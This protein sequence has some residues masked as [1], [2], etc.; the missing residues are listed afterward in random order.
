MTHT[1]TSITAIP[2]L[3]GRFDLYG[4]V[5]KGLRKAGCELLVRLGS[6]DFDQS[7]DT[8]EVLALLRTYLTLAAS[9]V[10]HED[11]HIH[12]ALA[13]RGASTDTVDHQHDDHREAFGQLEALARAV[14]TAWPMHRRATGRKL[15]LAF[16]A[17][18]AEDLA[19]MHEEETVTARA[20]WN[21][22]TDD[23]LSA[24]EM[25]I[26]SSLSPETNMAF[27]R[28]MIPAMNPL[29]RADMLGAMQKLAPPEIFDAVIEF[30][31]RPALDTKAFGDLAGRLKRAA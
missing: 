30:A 22:F 21:R 18:L 14:E 5:H 31:V 4:A 29:E 9:H 24:I 19:H 27:M 17:Y 26:V 10:C 20:L 15:Y 11:E 12:A 1:P 13:A 2:D 3:N 23:E 16:A 28:I 25:R 7:E 6:T 8:E